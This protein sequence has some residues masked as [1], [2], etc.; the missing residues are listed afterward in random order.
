M[1]GDKKFKRNSNVRAILG[2]NQGAL[3]VSSIQKDLAMVKSTQRL[4]A[5]DHTGEIWWKWIEFSLNLIKPTDRTVT[6][7][8]WIWVKDAWIWET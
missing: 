8:Q 6:G 3:F 2:T 1:V 7:W 5:P 4:I